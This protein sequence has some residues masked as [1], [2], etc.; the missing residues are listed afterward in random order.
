MLN[1]IVIYLLGDEDPRV[2]HVAAASLTRYLPSI[3]S[4]FTFLVKVLNDMR[5]GREGKIQR[6]WGSIPKSFELTVSYS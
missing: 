3:L 4:R 5:M 2:R 6:T 1:N